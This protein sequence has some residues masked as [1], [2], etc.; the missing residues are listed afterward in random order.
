MGFS[1][2]SWDLVGFHDDLMMGFEC[3]MSKGFECE[4]SV[5]LIESQAKLRMGQCRFQD[6]I[7]LGFQSNGIFMETLN[8]LF[9]VE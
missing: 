1:G 2:I 8:G 7:F 4:N 3:G 5:G 6:R 9:M